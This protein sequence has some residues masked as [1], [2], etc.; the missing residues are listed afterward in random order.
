SRPSGSTFTS[1]SGRAT[2]RSRARR[3]SASP[4]WARTRRRPRCA[5][6]SARSSSIDCARRSVAVEH[7]LLAQALA[8]GRGAHASAFVGPPGTVIILILS[9]ARAVP[10]TVLSRCQIVRFVPVPAPAAAEDRALVRAAFRDVAAEGADALFRHAQTVDRDRPRSEALVEAI[11][12]WYRDLLRAKA[13]RAPDVE[14]E[15]EAEALALD[16]MLARQELCRAAS[17]PH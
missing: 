13:G 12:L 6:R 1:G 14:V 5:T 16:E 7:P 8:S 17:P 15:R 3:R 9:R 10:A 2:S 11:W 4:W